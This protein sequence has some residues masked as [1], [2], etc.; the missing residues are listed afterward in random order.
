M[1]KSECECGIIGVQNFRIWHS[2]FRIQIIV[3]KFIIMKT[4]NIP[5]GYPQL[6][7]YLI[8]KNAAAFIEFTQMVLVRKKK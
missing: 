3:P 8:V 2:D 5:D 6:M 7:P 4:V 1:R